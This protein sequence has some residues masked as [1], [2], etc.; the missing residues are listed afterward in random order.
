MIFLIL[1]PD[2][3][4]LIIPLTPIRHSAILCRQKISE[5]NNIRK[6]IGKSFASPAAAGPKF[7]DVTIDSQIKE[8]RFTYA[9]DFIGR[10]WS[11]EGNPG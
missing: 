7:R 5:M 4:T 2:L 1:K 10:T 9:F 8:R 11:R 3:Y 6:S